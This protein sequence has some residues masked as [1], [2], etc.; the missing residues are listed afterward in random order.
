MTTRE[1][2]AAELVAWLRQTVHQAHHSGAIEDCTINTCRA[3]ADFLALERR[4]QL[5]H[6]IV[7]SVDDR[8]LVEWMQEVVAR[9]MRAEAGNVVDGEE[10]QS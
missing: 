8:R 5:V 7:D 3:A 6:T 1:L 4:R 2:A 10:Q 9:C